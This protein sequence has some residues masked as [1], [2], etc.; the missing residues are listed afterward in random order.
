MPVYDYI[1]GTC[2]E[3]IEVMHG[4]YASGPEACAQCGKGPMRKALHAPAVHFRG[5]GWAKKERAAS[6]MKPA[7][8][9]GSPTTGTGEGGGAAADPAGGSPASGDAG[10]S[11]G[12]SS[13]GG[14]GGPGPA[15]SGS[16]PASAGASE[17]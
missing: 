16:K 8:E 9:P 17:A 12:G 14:D 11:S 2:G 5:S 13:G 3:R 1:C 6:G 10:G 7:K 4:V 15:E